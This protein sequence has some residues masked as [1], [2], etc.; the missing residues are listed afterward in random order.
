MRFAYALHPA[1]ILL[2]LAIRYFGTSVLAQWPN[3]LVLVHGDVTLEVILLFVLTL[4]LFVIETVGFLI[5][6]R[7]HNLAQYPTL[8]I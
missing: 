2:F 4:I 7:R 3:P 1:T 5:A 6:V 8:L